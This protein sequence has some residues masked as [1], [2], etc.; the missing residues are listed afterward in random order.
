VPDE[1]LISR[2]ELTAMLFAIADIRKDVG[3][4]RDW[5]KE[6]GNDGEGPE[7]DS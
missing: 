2:Q 1:V 6:E 3:V 5:R 7:E 4:I